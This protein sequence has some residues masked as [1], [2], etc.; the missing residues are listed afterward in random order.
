MIIIDSVQTVFSLKFQSAPGSIGQVREA[1]TQFLFTAKG[2]NI[3]TFLVG[4]I[5]KDGSLAGPKAL[6][7]VVDTV[8][9][10]EGERHHS[11]RVVRAVKNRFGAASELGVFEM[12][13][14]GLRPV[15]NPSAL[16]LAERPTATPGSAVLCCLEGSRPLLVEVQAL[17]STS[18][19]GQSRRMAVGIDQNRLSLLLA[20]LEKR[21]GLHL[22]SD[23]VFVNIAGGMTIDEPAVDLGI[24]AAVAS[25]LRNRPIPQGTAV[26]GEVGLGGE[27][28][29]VA[30]A[31]LR[32]RE[33]E[34]MGFTRIVLPASNMDASEEP[35]K[36]TLVGVRSVGEALDLLL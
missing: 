10:F 32:I 11:H 34:Q 26:F 12:T 19:Y 18:S 5:T 36:A 24:V 25:S 14:T 29:G 2:H 21:A 35:G 13:G 9:Y 31:P 4:H 27:V 7:H 30:Q 3:P 22:V 23:D 20:V 28:R 6:E 1:A 15:P 16:F 33:A 17:V 8:L